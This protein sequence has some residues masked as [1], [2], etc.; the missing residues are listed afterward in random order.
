MSLEREV[1][2]K[3]AAKRSPEQ[4]REAQEWIETLLGKKFPAGIAYE[5]ALRDG[6]I[7]CE[8]INKMAPGSV[9]KVHT[10]GGDFKMMENINK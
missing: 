2:A 8:V 6:I 7:L 5:D 3:I 9:R 4:D 10:S 1:R